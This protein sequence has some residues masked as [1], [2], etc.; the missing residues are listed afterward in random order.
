M[1]L[2][3]PLPKRAEDLA[4]EPRRIT[5][6]SPQLRLRLLSRPLGRS[7]PRGEVGESDVQAVSPLSGGRV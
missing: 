5:S 4:V 6:T 7:K 2:P 1:L 3:L